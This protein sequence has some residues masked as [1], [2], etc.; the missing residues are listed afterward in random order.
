MKNDT[1][2]QGNNPIS[3][4][5]AEKYLVYDDGTPYKDIGGPTIQLDDNSAMCI[6]YHS[7][8][9]WHDTSCTATHTYKVICE[10]D[11]DNVNDN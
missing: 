1:V 9:Y 7:S 10:F 6:T 8:G 11:C 4:A 3:I 5:D 2:Y